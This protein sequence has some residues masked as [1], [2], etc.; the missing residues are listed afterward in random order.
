MHAKLPSMQKIIHLCNSETN[1]PFTLEWV[2]KFCTKMR[3]QA[4]LISKNVFC[5][6]HNMIRM[7]HCT[8]NG[9]HF[10][11]VLFS[12]L[13]DWQAGYILINASTFLDPICNA[14]V[15]FLLP[16]AL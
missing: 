3:I 14:F 8:L 16:I 6:F 2:C 13:E 9:P 1:T 7:F 15:I 11:F 4:E 5:S 10:E 12:A